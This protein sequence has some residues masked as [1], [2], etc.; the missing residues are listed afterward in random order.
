LAGLRAA[1]GEGEVLVL[2]ERLPPLLGGQ[3]YWGR[4][5]LVPLGQ[6]PE[7][8]LAEGVLRAALQLGPD[9]VALLSPEGIEVVPRTA[10]GPVTRAGVRLASGR[11]VP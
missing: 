2:G 7:P 4:D 11:D 6:R 9:E 10:L 1:L 8:A 5:V 3:R